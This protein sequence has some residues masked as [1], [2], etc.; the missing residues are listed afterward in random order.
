MVTSQPVVGPPARAAV[1]LVATV[2]PSGEAAVRAALQDLPGLIR[3]VAFRSPDDGLTC[4]VGCSSA[5]WDRLFDDPKP[6]DLHPFPALRGPRHHAPATPGDLLFHLRARRMDLCFELARLITELCPAITVVDEVH[7]FKYF[8]ERDL[9]GFVD[10]S[11]NPPDRIAAEAVYVGEEDPRFRGGSYVIV[12][13]YLH[14]LTAWQSLTVEEQERVIGRTKLANVELPDDVKPADSHVALNTIVV[15][16]VERRIVRDNMPFG[17]VGR[18]EFGTYFIGYAR[19]PAVTEQMLRNMFIGDPPGNT[20]RIL[21][22]STAVTGGLFFVPSADFLDDI[23][24]LDTPAPD[25]R[26]TEPPATEPPATGPP[27]RDATGAG[28]TAG[29]LCIGSLKGVRTP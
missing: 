25:T 23:D 4:V 26:A 13:K 10:G 6:R 19:T 17:S 28:G 21:D 12:Q 3:S 24:D 29:S 22:F 20:D 18:G 1:F 27:A 14:D 16:G 15:D 5:G 7:G 2:A 9:L 11:E 8:D